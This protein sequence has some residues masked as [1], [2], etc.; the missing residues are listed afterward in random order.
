MI[1]YAYITLLEL[2][3]ILGGQNSSE[4][5][6]EEDEELY[7]EVSEDKANLHLPRISVPHTHAPINHHLLTPER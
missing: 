6:D 1:F 2:D 3:P 5:E 4:E 7:S